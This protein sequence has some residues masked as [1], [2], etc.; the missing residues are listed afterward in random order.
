MM[1]R[2]QQKDSKAAPIPSQLG[3]NF[4]VGK[5]PFYAV[6]GAMCS[7]NLNLTSSVLKKHFPNNHMECQS[8]L[9]QN[10]GV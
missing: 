9:C 1:A 4:H 7:N 2:C 8:D 3:W 5:W 10:L 6:F